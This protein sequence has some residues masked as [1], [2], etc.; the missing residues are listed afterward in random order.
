[1]CF[2][3]SSCWEKLFQSMFCTQ[4]MEISV[5]N[6][7][8]FMFVS[9]RLVILRSTGAGREYKVS[10][11]AFGIEIVLALTRLSNLNG[12][13]RRGCCERS[14]RLTLFCRAQCHYSSSISLNVIN[15]THDKMSICSVFYV[16]LPFFR[17]P[18]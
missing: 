18:C 16:A 14:N 5:G 15:E 11:R 4:A 13:F 8:Y 10:I 3:V 17:P 7:F 2:G 1:M 6:H 12:M 9:F